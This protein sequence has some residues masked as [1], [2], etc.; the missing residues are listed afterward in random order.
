MLG[1]QVAQCCRLSRSRSHRGETVVARVFDA[2][3]GGLLNQL[4]PAA[5][6]QDMVTG[7]PDQVK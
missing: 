6:G 5:G 2:A 7:R 1:Q 3:A 4:G